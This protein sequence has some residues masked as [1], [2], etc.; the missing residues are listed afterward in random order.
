MSAITDTLRRVKNRLYA[1]FFLPSRM[2]EYRVLLEHAL[3]NGYRFYPI[4]EFWKLIRSGEAQRQLSFILRHDI[5]TDLKTARTL[6][7]VEQDLGI[8]SSYYFRL[9]TLDLS[10][11]QEIHRSGSEVGY[12]YEELSTIAKK[13]GWKAREDIE[14]ALPEIRARFE[15]NLLSLRRRTGLPLDIVAAHGD[16]HNRRTKMGNVEMLRDSELRARLGIALEVYDEAFMS[17]VT[18]R[19]SDNDYPVFW[20]PS[21]PLDAITRGEQV[22]YLL[23]HPR[24]W[25]ANV[26]VN[27]REDAQRAW[28]GLAFHIRSSRHRAPVSRR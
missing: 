18:S 9:C 22:I 2:H 23:V 27:A 25:Q 21:S 12:H 11:M 1:N 13:R 15:E 3:R 19:H 20:T 28:E 7:Q 5:D 8:R 17:H 24:P 16:W 26:R 6:W 14:Q 4:A 10:F